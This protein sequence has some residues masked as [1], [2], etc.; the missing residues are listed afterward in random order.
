[1]VGTHRGLD[2]AQEQTLACDPTVGDTDLDGATDGDEV[3]GGTDPTWNAW[4][5]DRYVPAPAP[6]IEGGN[7]CSVTDGSRTGAWMVLALVAAVAY[8]ALDRRRPTAR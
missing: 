6:V 1:M 4:G 8:A 7:G 5:P 2:D 3:T